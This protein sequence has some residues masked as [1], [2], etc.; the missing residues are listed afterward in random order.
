METEEK[1]QE[2]DSQPLVPYTFD[3]KDLQFKEGYPGECSGNL[4]AWLAHG[5]GSVKELDHIAYIE[6]GRWRTGEGTD[7]S[8]DAYAFA[9]EDF[10]FHFD[11]EFGQVEEIERLDRFVMRD[12]STYVVER[13]DGEYH[14]TGLH[15]MPPV[16]TPVSLLYGLKSVIRPSDSLKK[17]VKRQ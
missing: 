15:Y 6:V 9:K 10:D 16:T 1:R 5:M 3:D 2:L 7:Q 17:R 13:C 14:Q 4:L 12:G 8:S 11:A